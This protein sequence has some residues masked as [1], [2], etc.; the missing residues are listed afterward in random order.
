MRETAGS[1]AAP[2]ARCRKFR[3]GSFIFEPPFSVAVGTCVSSHAPRTEPYVRL[4]R[5]RLPPRVCD[6]ESG[7]IRSSAF[8]TRAWL[9]VQYV[10][11]WCVFPLAP[12][13]RSTDSAA[14]PPQ[15]PPQWLRFVR[16]LHCCR[17]GRGRAYAL[18][19][20]ARSNGSCS[21][22]ASR[23]PVRAPLRRR[24]RIDAGRK[25]DQPHKSELLHQPWKW[26]LSPHRVSP[27]LGDERTEPT[28]NPAIH[29]MEQ[30]SY[31]R[32]P[33]VV[34]PAAYNRVDRLD[35]IAEPDR[36]ISAGQAADLI[37]E[38]VHRFLPWDGVKI[39]WVGSSCALVCGQLE[40]FSLTNLVAEELEPVRDVHDAGLL[41][42]Q[43]DT[44]PLVQECARRRQRCLGFL[45]RAT[46]DDEVVRPARQP[47]AGFGH[48]V[49]KRR[50]IN[51]R[52]Q[53]TGNSALRNS[54]LGRLP[55]TVNDHSGFEK[56]ADQPQNSSVAD[57]L[58][59]QT[60]QSL[61]VYF[62]KIGSQ[63]GV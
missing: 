7:R 57:F 15:T 18:P 53:R 42:M 56:T 33:V 14:S 20:P 11:C 23:F 17:V 29:P 39:Q 26:I 3:R 49:I 43:T 31:V 2:A 30:F 50:E 58:G 51:V 24:R 63:V 34:P 46:N 9:W 47:I 44:E 36:S 55:R 1:A 21:F 32:L 22:P 13:L 52:P 41:R 59:N 16:R 10:L 38:P 27:F 35:H 61:L 4:S 60:N 6:G 37:L 5:I 45:T 54:G 40:P 28:L 19:L 62:V 25:V 8:V 48:R 12:A